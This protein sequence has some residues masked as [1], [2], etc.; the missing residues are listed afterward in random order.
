MALP[1]PCRPV[2]S[3]ARSATRRRLAT[4]PTTPC[5]RST[6][7]PRACPITP[8]AAPTRRFCYL[9]ARYPEFSSLKAIHPPG[10]PCPPCQLWKKDDGFRGRTSA[11]RL[12]WIR[13]PMEQSGFVSRGRQ[14]RAENAGFSDSIDRSRATS[15]KLAQ[16]RLLRFQVSLRRTRKH[17]GAATD[18]F[19]RLASLSTDVCSLGR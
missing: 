4:A 17:I 11:D 2:W 7:R 16:L 14:D 3:Q 15:P 8:R 18:S 12:A 1:R 6:L 13:Q 10:R 9:P 5:T 19:V